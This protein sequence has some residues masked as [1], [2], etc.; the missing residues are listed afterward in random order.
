MH[1]AV[2]ANGMRIAEFVFEADAERF[3]EKM[4]SCYSNL[5]MKLHIEQI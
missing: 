5:T 2:I 4:R 1:Y 3:V